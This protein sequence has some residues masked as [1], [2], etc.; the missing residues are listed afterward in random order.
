[1]P[2]GLEAADIE[3]TANKAWLADN[4]AARE[5]FNQFKPAL[6]DLA[7]AGVALD[8]SDGS[9]SAVEDIA[10]AWIVDNRDLADTWVNAGLAA[11]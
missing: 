11:G 1:M 2:D 9:Q 4:P 8:A 6:I 5:V 3:I 7:I 10:A